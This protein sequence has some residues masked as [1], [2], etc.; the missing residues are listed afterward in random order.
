[1]SNSSVF[2]TLLRHFGGTEND[3]TDMDPTMIAADPISDFQVL[4]QS[5]PHQ[6]SMAAYPKQK[7][8]KNELTDA[9]TG[10]R[11]SSSSNDV[12]ASALRIS[13]DVFSIDGSNNSGCSSG[14]Y[15]YQPQEASAQQR[16]NWMT[17]GIC[18]MNNGQSSNVP[19][20]PLSF[21]SMNVTSQ[22]P[23]WASVL[24]P[25]LVQ[26]SNSPLSSLPFDGNADAD[27]MRTFAVSQ[28]AAPSKNVV[29]A[30]SDES[31]LLLD[32]LA[33][34]MQA[35]GTNKKARK[36]HDMGK[37][38]RPLSAYNIFFKQERQRILDELP[39]EV[40]K[41]GGKEE[42]AAPSRR[43]KQLSAKDLLHRKVDFHK[44]AKMVGKR[45]RELPA[46][47]LE[48]YKSIADKDLERYRE[49]MNAYKASML[50]KEMGDQQQYQESQHN[51]DNN[52]SFFQGFGMPHDVS[53]QPAAMS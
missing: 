32:D 39:K 50:I 45:W 49:E 7:D 44:L 30:W 14:H 37:P 15:S 20:S 6:N 23:G 29:G 2:D 41:Q 21:P 38:K 52:N 27:T 4:S 19:V 35:H 10:R 17:S 9:G 36:K 25:S 46:S 24:D 48:Q 40:L 8:F 51:F 26:S 31:A 53:F 11:V 42:A 18:S 33:L 43:R 16:T 12:E 3:A 34:S 5:Q 47:E 13:S 1:M 22:N 28:T